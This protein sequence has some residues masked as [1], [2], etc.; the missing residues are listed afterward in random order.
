MATMQS[1][2]VRRR[3]D[4]KLLTGKGNY[5]ADGHKP[6][7]LHAVL[8][9]SHHAHAVI[10][11][12]D[13][14]AA[15]AMPGVVAVFTGA[16]LTD[17][18]PIPGGI[19]FPRPDGSP[20]PKTH[21]P[22]L[23]ADRVRFVGEPVA[24]V[25]SETMEAGKDAAEAVMVDYRELPLVTDAV[26][27]LEQGAAKVWDDVPD[28]I[29][30]LWKRGDAAAADEALRNAAH[31][32]RLQFTVSRVTANSMEPRGAW[33]EIDSD[34]RMVVHAAHQS[35]FN[36]RNGMANGNFN[37]KPTDI[38]VV[39]EDVGG[40]FGMKSGVQPEYVLA[41]WAARK[42]QRPVRW[43]EDRTEGFLTDEQ[44]RE[45][46]ITVELALDATHKFT[47]LKLRWDVNL[48][49][50]VTGRSGWPVGNIGG[51]AGVYDIP[52]IY[53]E[54]CGILTNT[55][56]TAAYRGAGR[57][58]ATYTIERIIDI[59]ARELGISPY[60]LRR[61]NLISPEAMPYKTALTFTYDC[62][63]FEGNMQKASE[64]AELDGF[65]ARRAEAEGRG[66]LRG[67]GLCNCIEVAGGPFLRPA[68]DQAALR[69]AADGTLVLRSG[70]MSVGQGLETAFT[71]LVADRFG[72]PQDNVRFESGDT[73]MLP[74][75]K[76]NGGSGALCIGG[77][78]VDLVVNK[79]ID[80]AKQVAAELLEA[81]DVDVV[82]E[83]GR[84][85]IA[86]TDR[87]VT[88][89][90]VARAAVIDGNELVE[91]GEFT[92]TAVTFP[93]GT[94]ICEVEIDPDT[95]LTE[96]VRYSAVEELGRV[97]NPML[98]A[99]QVHG[100]VVQG[101]GQAM[102]EQIIHDPHSGQML[103]ASFMD[104]IMPRADDLPEIAMATREVP[105][106][107]N[108]L[109]AKGVGE[110]GTVGAMAAAMNAVNDAL[111]PLGIR[112]FDMPA[113]PYRVWKAIAEARA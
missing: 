18:A 88:L 54:S 14:S 26:A 29:G 102:A 33:A 37:I 95:G 20:A 75:G 67:I 78:A 79:V 69:L 73:D 108:P 56:P 32:A 96:V 85:T 51:T 63:E 77:N 4:A 50:Y 25:L 112:H 110:A 43:I 28:N 107:V 59:A 21:R 105:T 87:S 17:V 93:N 55:V 53:A 74:G 58:E 61:R 5:S 7:M 109:G 38:R 9:R 100:G 64:L 62:G 82:F 111:A 2:S 42:L 40:S 24:V 81:A 106:K 22:L 11:S 30:F 70:S 98:V 49:A 35:P 15:R 60:E 101:V 80:K 66:K 27:A 31:V 3:E 104:Y 68:K 12:I 103:T 23:A 6:G 1:K 113:T 8:V 91:S 19:G 97:L 48:G 83:A 39:C 13:T 44:A 57:P 10:N 65:A 34:G 90:E 47:A 94:H 86:G 76:G 84:F 46:R 41:A 99:G 92:P 16:D 36:L 89:A 72:V 52:S 71:Q 45:M